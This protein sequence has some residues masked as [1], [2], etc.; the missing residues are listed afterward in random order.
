MFLVLFQRVMNLEDKIV[1]YI[2]PKIINS[3][4]HNFRSYFRKEQ[5][6]LARDVYMLQPILI[7]DYDLS[8]YKLHKI[9]KEDT[10]LEIYK[11]SELFL[12]YS[13]VFNDLNITKLNDFSNDIKNRLKFVLKFCRENI[14]N[15]FR[16]LVAFH[17]ESCIYYFLCQIIYDL[18]L[19][20]YLL[21]FVF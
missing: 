19:V 8:R 16:L 20:E 11:N 2:V 17:L 1:L 5:N 4:N 6:S 10:V 7:G 14:K 21:T 13:N 12:H 18:H 9:C 15:R 3:N